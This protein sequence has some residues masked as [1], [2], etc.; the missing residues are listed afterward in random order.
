MVDGGSKSAN[1]FFSSYVENDSVIWFGNRGLGAFRFNIQTEQYASYRFDKQ[2]NNQILNDVFAIAKNED[3]YWFGTSFG[4]VRLHNH[5]ITIF[6]ET[7]GFPNNTVHSILPGAKN[8]LWL[9]TNQG[10][11]RFNTQQLTFQ[12]L[13]EYH[14]TAVTEFSDGAYY[15]DEKTGNMLFGGI[16]GF[17]TIQEN[18]SR[19]PDYMPGIQFT[20]LTIF[21]KEYNIYDFFNERKKRPTLELNYSQNFFAVSFTA[22]DYIN[23]NDYTW[24]Y[25]LDELSDTWVESGKTG[26]AVF[27][28]ISPGNYTLSVKYKNNITGE[29]SLIHSLRISILPPLVPDNCCLY[30]LFYTGIVLHIYCFSSDP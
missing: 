24:L 12:T 21:G 5:E 6:N 10:V 18:D 2:T 30:G 20:D 28:N 3:G 8:E 22:I 11:I 27:T 15:L 19:Q 16:N 29:E 17:L 7:H 26:T 9:S 4:L 23:G 1:Y 25:K 13:R 14:E